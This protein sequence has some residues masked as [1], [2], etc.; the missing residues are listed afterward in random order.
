MTKESRSRFNKSRPKINDWNE[1]A[2][3]SERLLYGFCIYILYYIQL[4]I[5]LVDLHFTN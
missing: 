5:L 4:K 3:G 2:T 1:D